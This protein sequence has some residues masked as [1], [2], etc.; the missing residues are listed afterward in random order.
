MKKILF[1]LVDIL[2]TIIIICLPTV[3]GLV[4]VIVGILVLIGNALI[5]KMKKSR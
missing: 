4:A 2:V 1:G 5:T 3:V